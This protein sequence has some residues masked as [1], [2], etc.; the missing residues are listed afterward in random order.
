MALLRQTPLLCLF[1][2]VSLP[3]A[4]AAEPDWGEDKPLPIPAELQGLWAQGRHCNDPRRQ[5]HVGRQSLQFGTGR[6][7]RFYYAAPDHT[8][9]YGSVVPDVYDPAFT[10]GTQ[11]LT[12]DRE[13]DILSESGTD[14]GPKQVFYRC[15]ARK[16]RKRGSSYCEILDDSPPTNSA[17]V[18]P[19]VC[20]AAGRASGGA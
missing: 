19:L 17:A 20:C 5:L 8:D 12:Y 7:I 3:A 13:S 4:P 16:S 9:P 14:F 18:S 1:W 15:P 2:C 6:P 11:A 10:F